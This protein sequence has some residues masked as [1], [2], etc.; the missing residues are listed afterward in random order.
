M[1]KRCDN[2]NAK[3][4]AACL[5]KALRRGWTMGGTSPLRV[6]GL[7][8]LVQGPAH[9][10]M[11]KWAKEAKRIDPAIPARGPEAGPI[12]AA[13]LALVFH[14]PEHQPAFLAEVN[15][16]VGQ[17]MQL[18]A[19]TLYRAHPELAPD[20]WAEEQAEAAQVER[21]EAYEGDLMG[22]DSADPAMAGKD[23]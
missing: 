19:D 18:E 6:P 16:Y 22:I 5:K 10:H 21:G 15:R 9:A 23:S 17:L 11:L 1:K 8:E 7:A 14:N 3:W 20:G 12:R 2:A 13:H 4:Q